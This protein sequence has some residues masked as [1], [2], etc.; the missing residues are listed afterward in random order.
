MHCHLVSVKV[1]I[2]RRAHEWMKLYGFSFHQCRL[3]CLNAETVQGR[4]TVQHD[5]MLLDDLLQYIP[6]FGLKLFYHFFRIFYI[7]SR[8]V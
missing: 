8:S 3:E 5:R 2:E 7:M 1:G 6:H 4:R